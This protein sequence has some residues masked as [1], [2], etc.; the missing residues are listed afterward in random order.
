MDDGLFLLKSL[1][2]EIPK[3]FL[4]SRSEARD[5]YHIQNALGP[6]CPFLESCAGYRDLSLRSRFQK[7][8]RFGIS[9]KAVFRKEAAGV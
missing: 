1:P 8:L 2:S 3:L 5:P 6:M 9:E 4:K 7:K